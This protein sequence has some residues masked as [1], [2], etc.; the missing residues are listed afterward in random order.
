MAQRACT[1]GADAIMVKASSELVK[2]DLDM[3]KIADLIDSLCA[4]SKVV[5]GE[6]KEG[7]A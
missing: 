5:N 3:N 2:Y 6:S 1:G 7:A 4:M